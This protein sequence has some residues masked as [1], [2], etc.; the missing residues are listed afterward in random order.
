MVVFSNGCLRRDTVRLLMRWTTMLAHLFWA[1]ATVLVAWKGDTVIM[2]A[3]LCST[4]LI[5]KNLR[6]I[7]EFYGK[8]CKQKSEGN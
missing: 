2:I 7:L 4:Y 6:L 3:L 8:A 1:A 5:N